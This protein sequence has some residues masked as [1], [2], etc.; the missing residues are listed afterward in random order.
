[1]FR[2]DNGDLR[3]YFQRTATAHRWL[4][5]S[6]FECKLRVHRRAIEGP[7]L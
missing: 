4:L 1:L 3:L 6:D 7:E 5:L 2:L